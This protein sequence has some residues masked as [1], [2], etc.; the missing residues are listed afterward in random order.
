M[1]RSPQEQ[2]EYLREGIEWQNIDYFNNRVI[3]ELVEQQHKGIIAILDEACLNVGTVTDQMYLE[4][5]DGKLKGHRH[6]TSR[7]VSYT[8]LW[9]LASHQRA[10]KIFVIL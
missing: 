8:Q 6:Y 9:P 7:R 10:A 1:W 4:A 2:E 5:M 3:C